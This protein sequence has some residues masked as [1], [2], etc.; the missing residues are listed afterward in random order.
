MGRFFSVFVHVEPWLRKANLEL[1]RLADELRPDLILVIGTEGVRAGTLAQVRVRVP[2][3]LIYS[4]YPDSPHNLDSDRIHCLPFFD[5]ATASSPAWVDAFSRLGAK[6][7]AYQPFAADPYLHSPARPD[8]SRPEFSHDIAFIGTWRPEREAFLEHLADLDLC[9]WGSR[10]WAA[11]CRPGSPLPKKWGG[12]SIT[13]EE[14]SRVCGASRILL[15][16]MDPATWPGPNMRT[17]EQPACRAFS[18]V[19]RTPALLEHFTEGETIVSFDSVEEARD[20]IR[21]YLSHESERQ[22]I[23]DASYRL[24]IEGGHTYVDRARRLCEWVAEDRRV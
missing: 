20:K 22:R 18:L 14:F 7:V 10:Y 3:S 17:F 19:T 12:R 16:V 15:N 6:N 1:L 21:F 11:R 8:T 2:E 9:I 13:G 24:V 23:A 4:V 5:R